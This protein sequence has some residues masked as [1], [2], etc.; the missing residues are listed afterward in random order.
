MTKEELL[1]LKIGS[2]DEAFRKQVKENWDK[3]AKPLDSLGHFETMTAQI[4][5]ILGTAELNLKKKAVLVM[6]ADNGI[7][8]EGISQSGQ[9]VTLAVTKSMGENKSSVGKMAKSIGVDV[10]PVD[11]G[12]NSSEEIPGVISRKV[13]MGTRNFRKEPAMTEEEVLKAISTGIELV[14][15]FKAQGYEIFGTGE[16]GI[17]NTTTSSALTAALTG[18]KVE[19]VTGRGAGL[20][21]DGLARKRK[22]IK[23]ALDKY[24]LKNKDT[25]EI[26]QTVGGL[27]IA[28]LTGVF[29]GGAVHRVPIV[30]DGVIS[31]VAALIAERLCPG[32]KAFMLPSHR[33]REMASQRIMEELELVPVIDGGLALGEGTGAVMLFSLLDMALCLYEKQTTFADIAIEPYKRHQ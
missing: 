30:I 23:E 24:D 29:L 10:F 28:G 21:D 2:P 26:L 16:M 17:G 7:V 19:D 1:H 31:A 12:V 32:A 3:V 18:C 20:S 33:S 6:C 9:E 5:A 4:G 22:V 27:D 13:A 8:E 15:S 14:G 11:I 25:F